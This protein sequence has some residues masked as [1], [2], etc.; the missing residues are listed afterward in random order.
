M[1]L[2]VML[3]AIHEFSLRK[4]EHILSVHTTHKAINDD[5]LDINLERHVFGRNFHIYIN[6]GNIKSSIQ[7]GARLYIHE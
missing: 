6:V 2:K 3:H 5:N 4:P 7:V 1:M